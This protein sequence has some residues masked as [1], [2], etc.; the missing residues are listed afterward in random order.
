MARTIE[1]SPHIRLPVRRFLALIAPILCALLVCS[2]ASAA[3]HALLVGGGPDKENNT[4]QIE[5]HLR[6]VA[7]LVPLSSGRIVLFADGKLSSRDLSYTDSA[8][9]TPGQLALD[10]LLPN[11]GLGAKVLT[12]TPALGASLDGPSRAPAIDRAFHRL[13]ALSGRNSPPVLLYFAGHGSVADD[14]GKTSLY[15]LWGNDDLD[16]ETLLRE[17]DTLPPHVPVTLVMAQCFS[18]GFGNVIFRKANPDLPLNDHPIIGFFAA[19]SDRE[20]AGCGTET[21]SPLYQDFSS[22]FFGALSGRDKLGHRV[23]GADFDG[24][25]RVSCHEAWCYALIHDDSIDTPVCTSLVFLRRFSN[26]P[27]ATIFSYPWHT[28]LETATPGERAALDAL[29]AKLGLDGEQRVLAAY[30]RLMF[31]D[32]I[33]QPGQIHAYRDAQ[34]RL[35][36]LRLSSL[37]SLFK[38]WPALR[39][40]DDPAYD[41]A[42][43][44]AASDLGKDASGCQTLLETRE[45]FDRADAVLD[46]EEALLVRFTDLAE[47]IV[48]ARH[49]RERGDA[50]VKARFEA[51]WRAEQ[52]PLGISRVVR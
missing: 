32:P 26:V 44:G 25:G 12:R 18:G 33:G 43:K 38:K 42:T 27:D 16:P 6:F 19:E 11:D 49:L 48:R 40:R 17:I 22:Y 28:L 13:A 39:W 24:D 20:A 41:R 15:N 10:V 2:R 9:L 52:E 21:N 37:D 14:K 8:H 29:S 47:I 7:G 23:D 1:N 3:V 34:D 30:D 35:N 45:A 51:L 4:A 36:T 5:E 31:A 50:G 46:D